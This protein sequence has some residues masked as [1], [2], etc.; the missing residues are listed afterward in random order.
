MGPRCQGVNP[1][2]EFLSS[3]GGQGLSRAELSAEY[4]KAKQA[5]A[6]FIPPPY[7]IR[8]TSGSVN[9]KE[10]VC[11]FTRARQERGKDV[12][13]ASIHQDMVR[14][15]YVP[16]GAAVRT[17][18]L[19]L[20][21]S[22]GVAHPQLWDEYLLTQGPSVALCVHCDPQ[23]PRVGAY[24]AEFVRRHRLSAQVPAQ[25]GHESLVD[26]TIQSLEEI[27]TRY[28]RLEHV[29]LCSGT[30]IPLSSVSRSEAV[31]NG[32]R[33]VTSYRGFFVKRDN[34]R[35]V[36]QLRQRAGGQAAT[37]EPIF[38]VLEFHHQWM[39]ICRLHARAL[40]DNRE[41]I[42]ERFRPVQRLIAAERL[43]MAPD[44]WYP[45]AAIRLYSQGRVREH[46]T[47]ATYFEKD[48]DRH[49]ITFTSLA[50][51]VCVNRGEADEQNTSLGEI[52][53]QVSSTINRRGSRTPVA[54]TLRKVN[55]INAGDV[56]SMT[57]TLTPIWTM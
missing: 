10:Q 44:E 35:F 43:N 36:Q 23:H 28:P 32:A 11:A 19:M 15:G 9:V 13:K 39:T 22:T 57:N 29:V 2:I 8:G 18:F 26:A 42:L 46:I 48:G 53:H 1:W 5:H 12:A 33:N 56:Q 45:I 3:H 54:L 34:N 30:D 51:R 17:V 55:C 31:G 41:D 50:R 49:P 16:P 52:L 6:D 24:R 47:T 25:W 37:Y 27:L 21:H 7:S 40:V 38:R 14:T 4:A 20:I